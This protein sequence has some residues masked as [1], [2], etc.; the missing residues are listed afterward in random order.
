MHA[1]LECTLATPHILAIVFVFHTRVHS[2]E[3]STEMMMAF[4]ENKCRYAA[5]DDERRGDGGVHNDVK[6]ATGER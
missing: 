4:K 6:E 1:L 2:A 5:D 3:E